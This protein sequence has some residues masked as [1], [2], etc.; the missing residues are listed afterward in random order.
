M[1]KAVGIK[2][3]AVGNKG[4]PNELWATMVPN[5][6]S[7]GQHWLKLWVSRQQHDPMAEAVGNKTQWLKLW[8]TRPNG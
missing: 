3:K 2:G 5:G 8:A 1:A 6:Y 7:C 4:I